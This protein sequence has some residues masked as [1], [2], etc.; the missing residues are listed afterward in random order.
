MLVCF[1]V[2]LP[3]FG[4][5]GAKRGT[6]LYLFLQP[7]TLPLIRRCSVRKSTHNKHNEAFTDVRRHLCTGDFS[8]SERVLFVPQLQRLIDLVLTCKRNAENEVIRKETGGGELPP[9]R[10]R[11]LEQETAERALKFLKASQESRK[12][13]KV[14]GEVIV[15]STGV[16]LDLLIRS[17]LTHLLP[18]EPKQTPASAGSQPSVFASVGLNLNDFELSGDTSEPMAK[19]HKLL[20]GESNVQNNPRTTVRG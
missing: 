7:S 16:R 8:Q 10:K 1:S 6:V 20:T 11:R 13:C 19:L 9:G 4:S 18:G 15:P 12:R 17:G 3:E 14:P 2:Q 5:R